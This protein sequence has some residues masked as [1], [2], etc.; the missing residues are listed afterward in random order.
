VH[1]TKDLPVADLLHTQGIQVAQEPAQWQQRLGI[2]A[3]EASGSI[4]LRNVL[5]GGPAEAAGMAAN[6]EWLGIEVAGRGWRLAKVDDLQLYA[7]SQRKVTAL[8][9]RDR[10]LLRLELALPP[11]TTWRL[12][13]RDAARAQLW[14]A[15]HT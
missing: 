12:L 11:A 4:V 7:G 13:L 1:G 8:V 2:R 14:L 15:A 10:M 9:A 5:R 3:A 6:D